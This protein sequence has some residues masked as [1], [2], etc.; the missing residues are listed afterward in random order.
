MNVIDKS[1]G[2]N[3]GGFKLLPCAPDVCQACAVDHDPSFP[4]NAQSL[5]YQYKFMETNG[6]F[7]N[8]G[9][10]MAH[11]TEEMKLK[12]REQLVARGVPINQFDVS[13]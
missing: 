8:W 6:R 12:W 5:Y 2:N 11:C 1:K 10:A 9:D 7:P 13:A 3:L 4:H